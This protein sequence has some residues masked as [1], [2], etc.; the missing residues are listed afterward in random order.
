MFTRL[1]QLF[2]RYATQHGAL[3]RRGFELITTDGVVF[4]FLERV[5]LRQGRLVVEGWAEAESVGVVCGTERKQTSPFLARDDVSQKTGNITHATPGFRLELPLEDGPKM[6]W[7]SHAG[8]QYIYTLP[9][10]LTRDLS[11]M[12]R[13]LVLPFLRDILRA[14]PAVVI[15]Y[16]RR[17]PNARRQVKQLLGLGELAVT[18]VVHSKLFAAP[19]APLPSIPKN[20]EFTII[21]PVYNAFDLLEEVLQRVVEHTDLPYRLIVV[22]D[23]SSDDR[24]RPFLRHWKATLP[25][26]AAARVQIIEN[27]SNL[28]FIRSVNAAF[29]AALPYGNHVVLLNADAFVPAG[30]ASRLIAPIVNDPTVASVTPMSNDAEIFNVPIMG[31]RGDLK[32]GQG[33]ALDKVAAGLN[34]TVTLAEAPTG[35]GF[36]MAMNIDF[37]RLEPQFDTVFGRGYGEEV[38]WC[39]RVHKRH[40]GRHLGQAGL[41]VEHRGGSS[42]GSAEKLKL[43]LAN[44]KIISERYPGYDQLVQDF[45]RHDPLSS[46]RLALGLAWA[47]QRQTPISVYLAHDLG[48]GA[49]HY[50]ARRI[51][52][53]LG[54]SEDGAAVVLRVGGSQKW[55][56]ELHSSGGM[57]RGETDDTALMQR[58][59]ALLPVRHLVYSCGVGSRNP[60]EIPTT[61]ADLATGEPHSLEVL[62]HDFLPLSPSYTLLDADGVFRGVPKVEGSQDEAHQFIT[63]QGQRIS[64]ADWRAAWGEM[65]QAADCVT[66][67]S[68]DSANI[69]ACAY[70]QVAERIRIRPHELLYAVPRVSPGKT[71]DDVPVIGVLGNIGVQKGARLLQALS[72]AL[73][74]SE[75]ARLV[76]IGNID[77]AYVLSPPAQVHGSYELADISGLVARYG[78]SQW[79][80][81]SIWPETFSYATH[82]AIATGLPVWCFDLGAQAEAVATAAAQSGQ[83]GTISLEL[84]RD[85]VTRVLDFILPQTQKA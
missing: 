83:G 54:E 50:L 6:F 10:F 52:T 5:N 23:A 58:L 21:L 36:C 55:Q 33:D 75:A 26:A 59:L 30:W 25:V 71:A 65:M 40:G 35:V 48:G 9:D 8:A 4:G 43:V 28:G 74:H 79:L 2:K 84:V 70:P 45:I 56:I 7:A 77:P 34:P 64:L 80:I 31:R 44:N 27:P 60:V 42:F 68:S 82:E 78:I 20:T 49:E 14:L 76:V 63:P 22:E 67:F 39:R 38:D 62:F 1:R 81:P 57:L 12:R 13:R 46:A 41:F 51:Q 15:W 69:V 18:R 53:E 85:D 72:R 37:L 61:L 32:P 29:E 11:S 19:R 66:V 17:D 24:V 47:G 16:R 3:E 73:T